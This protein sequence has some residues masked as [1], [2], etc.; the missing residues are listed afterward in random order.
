[1]TT[2]LRIRGTAI[3]AVLELGDHDPPASGTI[4]IQ[5]LGGGRLRLFGGGTC[6]SEGRELLEWLR[7]E[8]DVT[9]VSFQVESG[10]IEVSYRDDDHDDAFVRRL[11]DKIFVIEKPLPVPVQR[12]EVVHALEGRVRLR[13]VGGS[14]EEVSQVAA[15]LSQK[16]GVLRASASPASGSILVQYD[17][18]VTDR[19]A[20]VRTASAFEALAEIPT[21]PAPKSQ[22]GLTAFNSVVLGATLLEIAPPVAL[23]A[24]VALTALPSARRAFTALR[25]RRASV[26]LLDLAAIGISIGTGQPATAAFITWLLGIGDLVLERT[27][28]RAR[29]AISHLMKLDADDAWRLDENGDVHKVDVK[30]LG[31]GDRIVVEAGERVAADGIVV[32]GS[33]SLDEKALTGESMPKAKHEG[34]RVLAATV[35]VQG[36][37]VVEIDRAGRDTTAA[38]IVQILEGAGSKPM[39]L[40]RE[41]E[42]VADRLV[43]PTF[44]LAGGAATLTAEVTRATSVLITDFGTGIRIAVPTSA[45]AAMTMAARRGVLVKGGQFLERMSK[46]DAIVF[47]KTGTLTGGS[48]EVFEAIAFNGFE[49]RDAIALAASAEARQLHP[50]AEALRR[51]AVRIEA[52]VI[53]AELGSESYAIGRGLEARVRGRRVMV[54]SLRWMDE[55]RIS[56]AGAHSVLDRHRAVACSSIAVAVDGKLAAVIGYADAPRGESKSV[57]SALKSGG[58]RE[59]VLLSGDA[60]GSV[61]SVGRAVGVDRAEGELMP[62]DKARIV[63]ELQRA[64]KVVAMIGD[65]INDAPALAVA[66]VGI[67]LEGGTDVA[68]ETADVVL[69]EGGLAKLPLA[70]DVADDAMAH[71]RRGLGI[72]IAPN[73][74][75]IGLGALGLITPGI[76]AA[77]NNGSTVVAA[78]AA[79]TPLWSARA[80]SPRA[81]RKGKS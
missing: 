47:D 19:H 39:S 77:V 26:D 8:P 11:R 32:R 37:I 80:T 30:K 52:G 31:V 7:T 38:K 56:L 76:A 72:V 54:G 55:K 46:V 21:E 49:L 48:P 79:L 18:A 22:L 14:S 35:V 12:I 43:L 15:L 74:L 63:K 65:G 67:S 66:D 61:E 23:G 16:E 1:M 44:A 50:I 6:G 57:V 81:R 4:A 75:A 53:A 9:D 69:L 27:Q 68:L 17:D 45:L 70:F 42:K 40:Q 10:S 13:V 58:R 24:A 64:G 33:A 36:Q 2:S 20:I 51:Y 34:D 60:K 25:D 3:D 73:A 62:E 78:L 29:I 59:V 28:R 71:V 5:R 41:T